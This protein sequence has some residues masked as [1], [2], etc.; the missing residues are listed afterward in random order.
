MKSPECA[1]A[2]QQFEPLLAA[3]G[4]ADRLGVAKRRTALACLGVAVPEPA[5]INRVQPAAVALEPI[6]LRSTPFL[7]A[8]PPAPAAPS[9]SPPPVITACDAAGCW[10]SNGAHYDQQGP[11]LLG[12]RGPCTREAALLNCP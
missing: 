1:A 7:A 8:A 5:P 10:D 6:R 11:L 12:P 9:A 2:R 3:G 4:P